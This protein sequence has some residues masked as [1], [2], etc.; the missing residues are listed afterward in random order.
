VAHF[1]GK[2]VGLMAKVSFFLYFCTVNVCQVATDKVTYWMEIADYD[3]GTAESLFKTRRWLYVAFMCHQAIPFPSAFQ[4][5][6][7]TDD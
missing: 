6:L 2:S 4:T 3:I 7:S 5:S 1:L